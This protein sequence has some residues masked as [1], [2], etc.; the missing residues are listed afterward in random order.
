MSKKRKFIAERTVTARDDNGKQLGF[1]YAGREYKIVHNK[2]NF[3][4]GPS[5]IVSGDVYDRYFATKQETEAP[6]VT[7]ADDE[8]IEE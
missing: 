8:H 7:V 6:E 2:K 4:M 1:I 5:R 3:V